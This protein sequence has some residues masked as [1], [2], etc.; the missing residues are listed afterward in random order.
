M[1]NM[2]RKYKV[3]AFQSNQPM[4]M[5]KYSAIT[6][7]QAVQKGKLGGSDDGDRHSQHISEQGMNFATL[8]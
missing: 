2:L 4:P 1:L 5:N 3:N 6:C 8:L 7:V